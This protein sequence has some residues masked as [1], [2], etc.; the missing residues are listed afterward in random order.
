MSS[1]DALIPLEQRTIIFYDD[2]LT[3]VLV[4]VELFTSPCAPFVSFLA[5]PGLG[6]GGASIGTRF[7]RTF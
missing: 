3:A 6:N 1:R 5:Y 4:D 2:E 7:F